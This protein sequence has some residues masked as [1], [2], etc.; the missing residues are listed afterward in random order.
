M[1]SISASVIPLVAREAGVLH[2][3]EL[4]V[5]VQRGA[6]ASSSWSRFGRMPSSASADAHWRNGPNIVG[7][8]ASTPT[9]GMGTPRW[10]R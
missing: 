9:V 6:H 7:V 8:S 4:G 1:F 10:G 2:P 3:L 5:A